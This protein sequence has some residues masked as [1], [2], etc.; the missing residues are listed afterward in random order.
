MLDHC[1]ASFDVARAVL[2]MLDIL[3][4]LRLRSRYQ[5]I[6]LAAPDGLY[7]RCSRFG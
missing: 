1:P 3:I 6:R 2:V 4:G 5:N 7:L